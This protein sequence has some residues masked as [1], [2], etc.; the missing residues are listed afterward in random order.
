MPPRRPSRVPT[1]KNKMRTQPKL[2]L[3]IC[4]E[5]TL[6]KAQPTQRPPMPQ[7]DGLVHRDAMKFRERVIRSSKG[8]KGTGDVA[9][10]PTA[11]SGIRKT[12][13]AGDEGCGE[14]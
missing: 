13:G 4:R 7:E 2:L 11:P 12:R 1:I 8:E 10:P 9:M 3:C 6:A 5:K 14:P